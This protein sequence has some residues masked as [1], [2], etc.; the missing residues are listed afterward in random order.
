[1]NPTYPTNVKIPEEYVVL[2]DESLKGGAFKKA[3]FTSRSHVVRTAVYEL[4]IKHGLQPTVH[5]DHM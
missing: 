2:I 5:P 1:M 4:L 3:G